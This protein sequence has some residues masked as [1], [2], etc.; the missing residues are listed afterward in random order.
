M[1]LFHEYINDDI[2]VGIR[3]LET[4][5]HIL[6]VGIGNWTMKPRLS[7]LCLRT[8]LAGVFALPHSL[9]RSKVL[10]RA[11]MYLILLIQWT[12]LRPAS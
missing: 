9:N 12:L 2:V 11:W 1:R 6:S 5:L 3:K 4:D 7:L 8:A 10:N